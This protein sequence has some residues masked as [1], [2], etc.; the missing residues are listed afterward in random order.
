MKTHTREDGM[1]KKKRPTKSR[2]RKVKLKAT[3]SVAVK[4]VRR[5]FEY[6]SKK[7]DERL[8]SLI[9][10]RGT[11]WESILTPLTWQTADAKDRA[12]IVAFVAYFKPHHPCTGRPESEH[13]TILSTIEKPHMDHIKRFIDLF[14]AANPEHWK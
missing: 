2:L 11:R 6:V 1:A 9:A 7:D 3:T 14:C 12:F 5:R 8:M 4:V 10:E 13:D